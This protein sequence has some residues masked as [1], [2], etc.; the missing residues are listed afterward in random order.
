MS[1]I[2]PFDVMVAQERY[3]R[4]QQHL[5]AHRN[6][7]CGVEV[8]AEAALRYVSEIYPACDLHA[9]D[10]TRTAMAA[11]AFFTGSINTRSALTP[12]PLASAPCPQQPDGR[13]CIH[14]IS[15][16]RI[17]SDQ[18]LDNSCGH[19]LVVV[20][21]KGRVRV[22]QAF[23]GQF[24]LAEYMRGTASMSSQ[25][26]EGWWARLQEALVEPEAAARERL[27]ARLLGADGFAEPVDKSWMS[28]RPLD[29]GL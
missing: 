21:A 3:A 10:C 22:L 1:A 5:A 27:F 11:L 24:T 16:T 26:F 17:P 14:Y 25:H 19:R 2:A 29:V 13:A 15:L 8:L 28:T 20:Q 6:M 4:T 23:K 12:V 7:L 9:T 18:P